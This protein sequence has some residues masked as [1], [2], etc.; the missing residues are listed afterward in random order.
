MYD[1][2][3]GNKELFK[4]IY[5]VIVGIICFIIVIRTDKLFR[6]SF[7]QGIRYFRNAFF[8][9][10]LAFIFR[11]FLGTVYFFSG[12]GQIQM[13]IVKIVF[14]FFLIMAG[15]FLLYSLIWKKFETKGSISSLFNGRIMLFYALTLIIVFL[16]YLWEVYT[17]M[18]VLQIVI[19]SYASVVSGINYQRNGEQHRFLRLYFIVMIL[20]L[21]AWIINFITA[22]F[23]NWYQPGII[24]IY[25]LNIIIFF[26]FL[27]GV[28]RVTKKSNNL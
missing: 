26:V 13:A 3:I 11:Y 14:E 15:F 7:H 23:F 1:W 20:N 18:F 4:L 25:I 6:L 9:Y 8:F 28:I 24:G 16:D 10:G 17:F 5:T 19:F 22:S 2:I 12:R 21:V 27:Y